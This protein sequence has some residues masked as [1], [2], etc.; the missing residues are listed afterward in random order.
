MKMCDFHVI[1]LSS[2]FGTFDA[3]FPTSLFATG[4]LA[5][6]CREPIISILGADDGGGGALRF[7]VVLD[8]MLDAADTTDAV[9]AN[10]PIPCLGRSVLL[11]AKLPKFHKNTAI[12]NFFYFT[13][14][15][16]AKIC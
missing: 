5:R 9:T 2:V 16:T 11:P 7:L 12:F 8:A 1:Y 3:D 6:L 14:I 15:L 4:K 10:E 13:T